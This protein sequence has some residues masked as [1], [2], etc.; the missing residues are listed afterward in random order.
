M[1]DSDIIESDL[2]KVYFEFKKKISNII[3]DDFPDNC[4]KQLWGA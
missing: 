2:E 3:K 4:N 1:H